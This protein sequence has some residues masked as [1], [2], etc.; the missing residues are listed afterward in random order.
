VTIL[1]AR[2]GA[3]VG[4]AGGT[5][6]D[7]IDPSLSPDGTK[8]VFERDSSD[9]SGKTFGIWTAK[10]NGSGLRQ[11]AKVG[12]HPLW[13][14]VDAKIAYTTPAGLRLISAAGGTSRVLVPHNVENVFGW[15]PDGK[16]I[17]F[18]AGKGSIGELAVVDV[19]TG[20]VRRL[21]QLYYAPTAVWSADSSELLA[22][23]VSKSQKC[24]S[25]WRVPVDGSKP[26]LI[27]SCTQP[28]AGR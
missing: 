10:T 11:V 26:T 23:T 6:L 3:V 14:P 2:S 25:T 22:N 27:S 20:K 19:A 7:N 17:A 16:S 28:S 8:V 13:S 1:D 5:K 12:E 21:L 4:T 15:S 24:W 9:G 18:E